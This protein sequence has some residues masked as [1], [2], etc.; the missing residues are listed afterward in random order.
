MIAT[1]R[2]PL[3][4]VRLLAALGVGVIALFLGLFFS[5][6]AGLLFLGGAWLAVATWRHPWPA[7]LLLIVVAP[8]LLILKATVVLGPVTLLKDVVILTLVVNVIR[9]G[10]PTVPRAL[11]VPLLALLAWVLVG[12]VRAD[13]TALGLLRLRDLL[14]YV[15]MILVGIR[16]I[17]S[18]D[19]QRQFLH[20]FLGAGLLV[21]I[22]GAAQWWLFPD[23]MVLRFDPGSGRWIPRLASVLAHPNH[24]GSF[25]VFL[26]PVSLAL[27][28]FAGRAFPRWPLAAVVS[29]GGLLAGYLTYS[30]SAWVAIA[31]AILAL[32]LL[33][34][35]RL[36]PRL[37]AVVLLAAVLA[38][39]GLFLTPRVRS[40]ARSAL[41]PQYASNR[42]RLEIL[43]GT[44]SDISNRGAVMGEGLG[45]TVR[46]LQR[47]A[48]ISLYELA[49]ASSREA[50]V[51]KARTFVDNGVVKTWVEL[52]V[53]G[54]VLF[55]WVA[56]RLFLT[57]LRR[58]RADPDPVGRALGL[59]TSAI[60]C[61][62]LPLWFFLDVPDL[63]PVNLYF[64]TFAG[65][66][67]SSNAK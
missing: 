30:R 56:V 33:G 14:L 31:A 19:R 15:P 51:A 16:L 10:G 57:A 50:Q 4:D 47:V 63:F 34:V 9:A 58:A 25:L 7:F 1:L 38:G 21:L 59:A 60:L 6:Q 54:L 17:R 37:T 3:G 32:A 46:L 23:G 66:S 26:L 53:V 41:D 62:L 55:G 43:A 42:E 49:A 35:I 36:R 22:L 11:A 2:K 5:A 8:F 24:L 18:A 39:F 40:L 65:L 44:F 27:I 64:W 28:L 12:L 20:A 13:A 61:G 48:P 52:G 45:D 29:G 67:A